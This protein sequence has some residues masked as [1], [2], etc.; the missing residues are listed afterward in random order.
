MAT[1]A[2]VEIEPRAEA[3]GNRI[4]LHKYDFR[5]VKKRFFIGAETGK[6][7]TGS[8]RWRTHARVY[9]L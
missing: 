9:R 2:T 1:G 7:T 8:G 5:G 6:R 3:F 4:N